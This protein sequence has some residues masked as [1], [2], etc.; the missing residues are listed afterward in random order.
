M[1]RP[2]V[3]VCAAALKQLQ[4]PSTASSSSDYSY[5]EPTATECQVARSCA[6][7]SSSNSLQLMV[8]ISLPFY[9]CAVVQQLLAD[10]ASAQPQLLLASEPALAAAVVNATHI[11]AVDSRLASIQAAIQSGTNAILQAVSLS[12]EEAAVL[13][14]FGGDEEDA[15]EEDPDW[16]WDPSMGAYG[17]DS[18]RASYALWVAG[19]CTFA[20]GLAVVGLLLLH[21]AVLRLARWQVEQQLIRRARANALADAGETSESSDS[22][23]EAGS[24]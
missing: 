3:Q 15:F 21:R 2:C 19:I 18:N 13:G 11:P 10:Q 22:D 14:V 12:A 16:L 23:S 4:H 8:S 6:G 7:D 5:E 1:L 20:V 17:F 9:T 24:S